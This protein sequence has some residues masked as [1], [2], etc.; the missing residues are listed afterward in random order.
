VRQSRNLLQPRLISD[1]CCPRQPSA[2]RLRAAAALRQA[3][4]RCARA[5]R[6]RSAVPNTVALTLHWH[7]GPGFRQLQVPKAASNTPSRMAPS[8]CPKADPP[9]CSSRLP[10]QRRVSAACSICAATPFAHSLVC[11]ALA[12]QACLEAALQA[13][14]RRCDD[15]T[16]AYDE[17]CT[18][19]KALSRAAD[20]S[21]ELDKRRC[22]MGEAGRLLRHARQAETELKQASKLAAGSP[23][24]TCGA[25]W[26]QRGMQDLLA[27]RQWDRYQTGEETRDV[28]EVRCFGFAR[29]V[30]RTTK[31]RAC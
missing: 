21:G 5:T 14:R 9:P 6:R 4:C 13:Q 2:R 22:R 28:L 3:A 11:A 12:A 19:V 16:A 29:N 26:P 1:R 20:A 15:L 30:E 7:A 17:L 31:L 24:P 27:R 25:D 8:R 10:G 23:P 18:A